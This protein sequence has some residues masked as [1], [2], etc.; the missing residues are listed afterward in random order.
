MTVLKTLESLKRFSPVSRSLI[1][2]S[3]AIL[4]LTLSPGITRAHSDQIPP[5]ETLGST[6]DNAPVAAP[7]AISI[8]NSSFESGTFVNDGN[9]T[10]VLPLGST[11]IPGWTVVTDQVAWII[12]PNPWGLSAQDGNRFLD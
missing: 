4:V 1:A 6:G 7:S 12:S 2:I 11:V 8:T 9:G 3:A 5:T 10:M